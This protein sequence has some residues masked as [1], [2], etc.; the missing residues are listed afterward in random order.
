MSEESAPPIVDII[1]MSEAVELVGGKPGGSDRN[2]LI[3]YWGFGKKTWRWCID[4]K[5]TIDEAVRTHQI[6]GDEIKMVVGK[7]GSIEKTRQKELKKRKKEMEKAEK[8]HKKEEKE[9]TQKREKEEKEKEKLDKEKEKERKKEE[10]RRQKEE[11]KKDKDKKQGKEEKIAANPPAETNPPNEG[12]TS[13]EGSSPTE[14][15]PPPT[16]AEGRQRS[17]S[18]FG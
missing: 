3:T 11:K 13:I 14:N 4:T 17:N 6:I 18:V 1:A 9:Q 10:E 8:K 2:D 12:N 5:M 7:A 16:T 15:S